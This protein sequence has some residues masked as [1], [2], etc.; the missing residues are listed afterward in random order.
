MSENVISVEGRELIFKGVRPTGLA[1]CVDTKT[2]ETVW[3]P[4]EKLPAAK[5]TSSKKTEVSSGAVE[6]QDKE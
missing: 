1:R 3:V 4:A 2:G 5:K 6:V